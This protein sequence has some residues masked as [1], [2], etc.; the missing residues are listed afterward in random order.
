MKDADIFPAYA[1]WMAAGSKSS[2][3]RRVLLTGAV[4]RP[5]PRIGDLDDGAPDESVSDVTGGVSMPPA[6]Q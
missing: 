4:A 1:D 6:R 5:L 2:Q 3:A